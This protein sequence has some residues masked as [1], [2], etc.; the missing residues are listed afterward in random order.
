MGLVVGAVHGGCV[1]ITHGH[2]L[3]FNCDTVYIR[4]LPTLCSLYSGRLIILPFAYFMFRLEK[5][6]I[7]YV[8][9][10]LCSHTHTHIPN[11]NLFVWPL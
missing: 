11:T 2:L 7:S 6:Q 4:I 5:H 3:P 10:Y 9:I 8:S 1:M